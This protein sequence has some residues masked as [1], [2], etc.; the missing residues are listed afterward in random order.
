MLSLC[1]SPHKCYFVWISKPPSIYA[2]P[3]PL[4]Y[5]NLGD[6]LV[7]S[8]LSASYGATCEPHHCHASC[9][10]ICV[11]W[12]NAPQR[13]GTTATTYVPDTGLVCM[14]LSSLFQRSGCIVCYF[15][16]EHRLVSTLSLVVADEGWIYSRVCQC[17]RNSCSGGGWE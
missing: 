13:Y 16:G 11:R 17:L 1:C 10:Q 6:R 15:V 4:S 5:P 12:R 8:F 7:C 9:S 3:P 14:P 2:F